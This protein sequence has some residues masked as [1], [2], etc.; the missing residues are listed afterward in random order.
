M[1]EVKEVDEGKSQESQKNPMETPSPTLELFDGATTFD[2]DHFDH[3]KENVSQ[4]DFHTV[5]RHYELHLS[6]YFIIPQPSIFKRCLCSAGLLLGQGSEPQVGLDNVEL[7]PDVLRVLGLDGRVDNDIVAGH[8]VD[9]GGDAVL[10][11]R[12]Q[13]VH[14]AEHF[15]SVATC[16][17]G[18]RENETDGLL[19]VDDEDGADGEGNALG[20]DVGGI[21]VIDP[22]KWRLDCEVTNDCL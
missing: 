9:G 6:S 10:V 8:P 17:G 4:I 19:G 15:G 7:G 14:H 22:G 12:L 16:G 18:V 21:L 2:D 20:V 3:W 11:T 13:R 1:I 5:I